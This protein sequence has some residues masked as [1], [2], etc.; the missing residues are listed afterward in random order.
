MG[1]GA[2]LRER[3]DEVRNRVPLSSIAASLKLIRAGREWK[4]CCPFHPDRS[5][6]FTIYADD[7]RF[8]CFGC[9]AEGDVLDFVM[10][11]H[12]V[13]LPEAL[14]MLAGEHMPQIARQRPLP[15]GGHHRGDEATEIW[16]AAAAAQGTIAE[17]YLRSRGITVALP[18]TIRFAP[19]PFGRGPSMPVLVA[20]V[21]TIEGY[22]SGIQR[23]FL[24]ADPIGKAQLPGGKAKYSLGRVLGGAIRLGAATRSLLVAEGLEDGLS[25]LQKL[26]RPVWVSAGAGMLP[27]MQL[28]DVVEAVIIGADNDGAG[29]IAA[30]KAAHAFAAKGKR[31]R[32]M[33]PDPA[34][35]D[36]NEQ[37][38]GA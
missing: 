26:G 15:A 23:T 7:R 14:R 28:P 31:V 32:I 11:L 3:C 2:S 6:S 24:C 8:M 16:Q 36:F 25:L 37:L 35:K 21:S 34:Y 27:A 1:M 13:R 17:T 38:L 20:A 12:G 9:G 18:E 5:P 30:T 4:A 19:L 29:E 10:R 22:V 33:R